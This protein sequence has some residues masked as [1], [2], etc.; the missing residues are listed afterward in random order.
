MTTTITRSR[1]KHESQQRL[2]DVLT[3]ARGMPSTKERLEL[4]EGEV[5][6][7]MAERQ[8]MLLEAVNLG[9]SEVGRDEDDDAWDEIGIGGVPPGGAFLKSNPALRNLEDLRRARDVT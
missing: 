7:A 3:K 2:R 1:E 6:A 8:L 5:K 4:L 9:T